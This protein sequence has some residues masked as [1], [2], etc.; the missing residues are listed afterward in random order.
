MAYETFWLISISGI[1]SKKVKF[2]FLLL[3]KFICYVLLLINF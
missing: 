1:T 3:V 2:R